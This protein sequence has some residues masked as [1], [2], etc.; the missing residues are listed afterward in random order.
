[1]LFDAS[2]FSRALK[3]MGSEAFR[4]FMVQEGRE[5]IVG[6]GTSLYGGILQFQN[7]RAISPPTRLEDGSIYRVESSDGPYSRLTVP[8]GVTFRELIERLSRED[9][10]PA[11]FPVYV[12]GTIGGFVA[13]NGSGFG[14]YKFGFVNA[15]KRVH[16]LKDP[17][18]VSVLGVRYPEVVESTKESKFS[19]SGVITQEGAYY[20]IPEAYSDSV[21]E[22]RGSLSTA[23]LVKNITSRTE[24]IIKR[25]YLPVCLRSEYLEVI[26]QFQAEWGVGY[27]VN[28]NS[29]A[30]YYVK[31]GSVEESRLEDLFSYLRK[32]PRVLPFPNLMEYTELHKAILNRAEFELKVPKNLGQFRLQYQEAL[33]CVNCS[34]CLNACLAYRVTQDY[35][36]SPPGKFARLISG[37]QEF[38]QCFGCMECQD[39]CPVGVKIASVTEVLPRLNKTK[40]T[41]NVETPP[42]SQRIREQEKLIEN[43]YKNKPPFM[44][45]VGCASKYDLDG[46]EGF[47]HFLRDYGNDLSYSPR[48]KLIDGRCCGFEKYIAGDVEGAKSDAIRIRE[49]KDKLGLQGV[50]FLCPEGLY[51]YNSLSGDKG[52]LAYDLVKDKVKGRVHVGCWM[53]KMG[54][55]GGDNECAGTFLTVYS[56]KLVQLKNKDVL[57]ICPFSTWK[58]NTKSVYST[59]LKRDVQQAS[60]PKEEILVEEQELV[61]WMMEAFKNAVILSADEVADR[62]NSWN[63]GG[64]NYFVLLATPVIRKKFVNLMIQRLSTNREVKRYFSVILGS[65]GTL[66]EKTS[67]W[68]EVLNGINFD[69]LTEELVKRVLNSPKLE[70]GSRDLVSGKDFREVIKND[71][72]KKVITPSVLQEIVRNVAYM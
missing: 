19:W 38:E 14:S 57:T 66:Q 9:I 49:M 48:V 53:R 51:V 37:D 12:E 54:Y 10:F 41:L 25:D 20:Y 6:R 26:D 64:K 5:I 67:R 63:L 44:L 59:F 72:L 17:N 33:K 11:L 15:K 39:A 35:T 62:A 56:G 43:T 47:L 31:C 23:E 71:V 13:T 4:K 60:L 27:I 42:V 24:K 32:N 34:L 16:E 69:E 3:L 2:V 55:S 45:F 36:R 7:P 40:S 8:A 58:Y 22:K 70:Y 68:T 61:S 1:M 65:A 29:P 18:Y 46:L 28:Y 50:Y 30:R 52:I 21:Q